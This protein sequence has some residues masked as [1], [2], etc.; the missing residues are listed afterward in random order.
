M[1][2]FCLPLPR[3]FVDTMSYTQ[4]WRGSRMPLLTEVLTLEDL[5]RRP[6][7]SHLDLT[8]YIEII[9]T[10][11]RDGGVGGSV[12][13]VEHEKQRTVKGRLSMEA[14][15]QGYR[16]VWRKAPPGILRFVLAAEGESIPG[17]R[18]RS[19]IT[20]VHAKGR[21]ARRA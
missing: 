5:K 9:D 17:G 20:D 19:T 2:P 14:K 1:L 12:Q 10:V 21:R 13:L 16:L 18:K 15:Q 11:S 3:R 4:T 6:R 8:A 7:E